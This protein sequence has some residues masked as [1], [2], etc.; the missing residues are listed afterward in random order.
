[1]DIIITAM[2]SRTSSNPGSASYM[3]ENY[4]VN[5]SVEFM[6]EELAN[7]TDNFSVAHK[8]GEGGFATVYYGEIRG[9][10]SLSTL[11]PLT[12]RLNRFVLICSCHKDMLCCPCSSPSF[13]LKN[14]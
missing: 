6:Y 1:M 11:S 8:I 7:C 10:V 9:Q 12:L 4:K 14:L 13:L 5:K 3:P 2:S